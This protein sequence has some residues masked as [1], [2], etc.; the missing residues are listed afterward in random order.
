M[1]D[2]TIELT[3]DSEIPIKYFNV[4]NGVVSYASYGK[5]VF[6]PW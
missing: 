4:E 1:R 5:Y 2:Y 3:K 6:K